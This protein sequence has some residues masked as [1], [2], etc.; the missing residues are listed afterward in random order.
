[1]IILAFD[2]CFGACSASLRLPR[3]GG[4]QVVSRFEL[5]QKGHSERLVPMI[6]EVLEEAGRTAGCIDVFA[7]TAGPGSFTGVRTGIAVARALSLAT[8]KPVRGTSSLRVMA[9]GLRNSYREG[10]IAI[11][12]PTRDGLIY[13]QSFDG[14]QASALIEP[15]VITPQAA[16]AVMRGVAHTVAGKGAGLVAEAA[17]LAGVPVTIVADPVE[18]DAVNMLPVALDL[19]VLDPPRPLYLREPDAKPQPG[20]LVK[21]TDPTTGVS[22]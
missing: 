20:M 1:M 4:L 7:V 8:G 5:M 13:F 18:A 22:A 11:A 14:P 2:T 6:Q 9:L 10:A 3:S 15:C 19:A 16:V 12:I 17:V 21:R